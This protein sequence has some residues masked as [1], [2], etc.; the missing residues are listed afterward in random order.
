MTIKS[1]SSMKSSTSKSLKK[2]KY[3][4][5]HTM[6]QNFI[7]LLIKKIVMNQNAHENQLQTLN[8]LKIDCKFFINNIY[9][10]LMFQKCVRHD[11]E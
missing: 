2:I 1:I 7:I 11:D 3:Q 8:I 4:I 5:S 10:N 6:I 9:K